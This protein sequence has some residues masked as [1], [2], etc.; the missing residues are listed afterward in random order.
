MTK[1]EITQGDSQPV[2]WCWDVADPPDSASDSGDS[3]DSGDSD[4]LTLSSTADEL[5]ISSTDARLVPVKA[6]AMSAP[7]A[8][9]VAGRLVRLKE[10]VDERSS[11]YVCFLTRY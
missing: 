8:L 2:Q 1:P 6:R 11:T 7:S 9:A 3:G 4:G 5:T 10:M